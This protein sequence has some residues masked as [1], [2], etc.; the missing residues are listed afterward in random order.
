MPAQDESWPRRGGAASVPG[1]TSMWESRQGGV[2]YA[3]LGL[4]T[5]H[6]LTRVSASEQYRAGYGGLV[7]GTVLG[8]VA[9]ASWPAGRAA[10][11]GTSG[12]RRVGRDHAAGPG[13]D[14]RHDPGQAHGPGRCPAGAGT[15]SSHGDGG[16]RRRGPLADR[17]TLGAGA[18]TG[19]QRL[20]QAAGVTWLG[21]QNAW[22]P[23][24][25]RH[26][27]IVPGTGSRGPGGGPT[28]LTM[29]S[30]A[31]QAAPQRPDQWRHGR[32]LAGGR[33]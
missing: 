25:G 9:A 16:F 29:N 22:G 8:G 11:I 21:V 20:G 6:V 18:R 3:S 33:A 32:D 13:G 26:A 17:G 14:H 27:A 1:T 23:L 30:P 5:L 12:F 19:R 7:A 2:P 28:M 4:R 10:V 31:A 15:G 24:G